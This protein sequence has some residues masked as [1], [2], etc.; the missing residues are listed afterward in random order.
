[1]KCY[2]S[3]SNNPR[4][5]PITI[6]NGSIYKSDKFN[7]NKGISIKKIANVPE[8]YIRKFPYFLPQRTRKIPIKAFILKTNGIKYANIIVGKLIIIPISPA[9]NNILVP[10]TA[11]IKVL[12]KCPL[13]NSNFNENPIKAIS[14]INI[15]V[16]TNAVKSPLYQLV[17]TLYNDRNK[18]YIYKN[19]K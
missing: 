9:R 17:S 4:I 8:V 18:L 11:R 6:K 13:I 3:L 10:R 1:M 15:I 5:P 19:A 7:G 16:I 2:Y 14:G 12:F